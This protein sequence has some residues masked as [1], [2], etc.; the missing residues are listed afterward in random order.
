MTEKQ[1]E[2]YLRISVKIVGGRAYKWT[3]PGNNGVPDRIVVLPKGKIHFVELKKPK[4]GKTASLQN[5]QQ[6]RLKKLGANV[7]QLH[8]KELIDS[9][10]KEVAR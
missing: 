8:T 10:I 6:K 1:I 7:W 2:E 3:S 9:F 4:G 5:V